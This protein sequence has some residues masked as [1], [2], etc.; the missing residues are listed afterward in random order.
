MGRISIPKYLKATT[1]TWLKGILGDYELEGHQ[2]RLLI[3]A[4]ECWDRITQAREAI[5]RDGPYFTSSVGTPKAH[6]ALS[7]ERNNR[8]VFARL[9]RELNLGVEAPESRP[10]TLKY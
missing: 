6:P 9:L 5:E 4:G 2:V 7:E 10:P 1:R 8:V 3:Q